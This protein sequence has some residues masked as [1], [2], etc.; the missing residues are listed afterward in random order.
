MKLFLKILNG[1][2]ALLTMV[3]L[4]AAIYLPPNIGR[5]GTPSEKAWQTAAIVAC[6]VACLSLFRFFKYSTLILLFACAF[7][8]V[9]CAAN[10][11]WA[12]G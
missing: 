11:H 9:S 3:V 2:A 6:M 5:D 4:A 7:F 10:F 12:G 8:F 1:L